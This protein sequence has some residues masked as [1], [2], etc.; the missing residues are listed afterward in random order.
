MKDTEK[1]QDKEK[2]FQVYSS[3]N[4]KAE[5][6]SHDQ[7]FALDKVDLL[8]LGN[9]KTSTFPDHV[10]STLPFPELELPIALGTGVRSCTQYPIFNF[11]SYHKLSPPYQAFVTNLSCVSFP[12]TIYEAL[13]DPRWKEAVME[14]MRVL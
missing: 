2:K 12:T 9:S 14:E 1:L 10:S 7:S 5:H 3:R 6:P 13:G 4:K 8:N 11:M